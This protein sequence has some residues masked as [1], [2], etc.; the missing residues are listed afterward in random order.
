MRNRTLIVFG[1]EFADFFAVDTGTLVQRLPLAHT[2]LV[3]ADG[4]LV[5]M[6]NDIEA[7]Q[8]LGA[9]EEILGDDEVG[10]SELDLAA[11]AEHAPADASS[12]KSYGAR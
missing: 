12:T 3:D 1:A 11:T 8:Y 6:D 10:T 9:G 5:C 4:I 7:V 2:R